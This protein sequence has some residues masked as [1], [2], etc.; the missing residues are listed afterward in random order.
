MTVVVSCGHWDN[1]LHWCS[2]LHPDNS[3][4]IYFF[5]WGTVLL[6]QIGCKKF[7]FHC[8]APCLLWFSS[9][10]QILFCFSSVSCI[11]YSVLALHHVFCSVSALCHVYCS[12][13]ALHHVY[14]SV[15]ALH[16]VYCSVSA[17]HHVYCSHF[18]P[19]SFFTAGTAKIIW[20]SSSVIVTHLAC[21]A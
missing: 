6:F 10:P 12:G 20:M 16:H 17:L 4:L 1:H 13:S 19:C 2:S 14:C 8:L 5:L 21:M 3:Q 11:L 15:S 18:L 9:A 7:I